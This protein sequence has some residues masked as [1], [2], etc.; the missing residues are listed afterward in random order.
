MRFALALFATSLIVVTSAAAQNHPFGSHRVPY[1]A[2]AIFP[3][4]ANLDQTTADFYD[5]WKQRFLLQRCGSGRYVVATHTSSRNLTVSEGH[6]YGMILAALMAGH[7][8]EARQIFDGMYAYFRDHPTEANP[9]LMAWNQTTSC[10]NAANAN[11]SASD[12]DLDIA[13]ALLVADKQWGSCGAIDYRGAALAVLSDIKTATLDTS[14]QYVLLGNWVS[15]SDNTYYPSTRSSDF[16]PDHYRAFADAAAD[17]S[18]LALRNATFNLV[19]NLQSNASPTT[20]LLPDF[21]RDPLISPTPAPANFLESPFDGAYNYNACRDP[22]RLATDFLMSGDSRAHAAVQKINTWVRSATSNSPNLIQSGYQLDGTPL[23]GSDYLSMAFVAPLGVGA[24]VD[25]GNQP[26]LDSLWDRINNTPITEAGYYENTLKLLAMVVMSGNWWTPE[27]VA[28]GCLP[29]GT[30]ACTNG[31]YINDLRVRVNGL[32]KANGKQRLNLSGRLFFPDGVPVASLADGAQIL[33]EDL[34]AGSA[35]LFALTTATVAV[36]P[37]TTS[38]CNPTRDGWNEKTKATTYKNGSGAL[39]APACTPGSARGLRRIAYHSVSSR[40]VKVA[41]T[42]GDTTMA[43]PIGPLRATL[44]LGNTASASANGQCGLSRNVA[45]SVSPT[46][47]SCQ[48]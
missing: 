13:F 35:A 41:I 34:G 15:G 40:E 22:W 45:C 18:W 32:N 47:A 43:S 29:T 17:P 48:E 5:D 23:P 27:A 30:P 42:T 38:A 14:G 10:R 1:T 44:A 24:M 20:G 7:D 11:D 37:S 12:G 46:R 2:G 16:M 4:R 28:G 26:W 36:P 8:P 9:N 33:L 39:D 6:G 31:G 25:A 19:S 21:V 3:N